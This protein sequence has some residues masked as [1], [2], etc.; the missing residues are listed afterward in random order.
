MNSSSLP[1]PHEP[2]FIPIVIESKDTQNLLNT[3]A[4][5]IEY[6]DLLVYLTWRQIKVRYA[7]SVLGIGWA[8]I[9]PLIQMI[10]FTIVFGR[11][12]QISSDGVPYAIF[13]Y[14]ALVPWTYFA[15]GI[16]E[17]SRTMISSSDMISKVYF[18]RLIL[19][20]SVVLNQLVDFFIALTLVVI[21][22]LIYQITP[23]I[24]IIF[25]PILMIIMIVCTAGVGMILGAMAIQYR[26]VAYSLGLGTRLLMYVAPVVYPASLVPEPLRLIYGINPLA[27][28]IEGFR[29]AILQTIPMPWDL[30]AVGSIS[31]IVIFI[32]GLVYFQRREHIFADIV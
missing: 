24:G 27:G 13:S 17:S 15:N 22:L 10:I 18:P 9:N 7:Q 12:A 2:N 32:I 19:P 5:I 16:T 23:G 6:R 8:I 1:P 3:W 11:L 14:V 29:S 25:L 21:L 28:V 26:D 20:L 31:S 30:I 4:E